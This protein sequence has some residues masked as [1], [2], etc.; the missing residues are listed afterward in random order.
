M[1]VSAPTRI[2]LTAPCA[3]K[4]SSTRRNTP[5]R[6]ER[7]ESAREA[8]TTANLQ[9]EKFFVGLRLTS[10]GIRPA[11]KEWKRFEQPI[12]RFIAEGLLESSGGALRLT[13]RGVL[14]SNEVFEEFISVE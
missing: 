10:E 5:T 8:A 3:R 6:W 7:R 12:S 1:P 11:A 2:R 9:E 14:F 13:A 4:M